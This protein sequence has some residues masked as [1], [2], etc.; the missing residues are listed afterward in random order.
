[1]MDD[2]VA[3][4]RTEQKPVNPLFLSPSPPIGGWLFAGSKGICLRIR[5]RLRCSFAG[6]CISS[7]S[8]LTPLE[9]GI[10]TPW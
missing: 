9:A 2:G 4:T 5:E 6:D 7:A 3:G 8:R 1:M 10:S